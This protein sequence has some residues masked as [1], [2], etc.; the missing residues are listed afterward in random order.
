[1]R[2]FKFISMKK[3][4]LLASLMTSVLSLSALAF[5]GKKSVGTKSEKSIV[6]VNP[7]D[8]Y[9]AIE[10]DTLKLSLGEFPASSPE[11]SCVF[12][13]TNTGTAPLVI[14]QALASC[15]CTIPSFS[16][17]PVKPGCKGKIEVRYNGKGKFPGFFSKTIT[18]RSNAKTEVVRLVV[19]GTMTDK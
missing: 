17:E 15:G 13:F 19:E 4:I 9:A 14:N 1:M 16:K 18:I 6:A 8:L 5:T 12:N 10:F 7:D 3:S 11:R 2:C